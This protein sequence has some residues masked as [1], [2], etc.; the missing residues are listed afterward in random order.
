MSRLCRLAMSVLIFWMKRRYG[1]DCHDYCAGLDG[2]HFCI[3]RVKWVFA[4]YEGAI[5]GRSFG[6]IPDG[7]FPVALCLA[8][9]R[10][11]GCWRRSAAGESLCAAGV[12]DPRCGDR[13]HNCVSCVFESGDGAAG[14]AGND[15]VV[16]SFLCVPEE[17][18]RNIYVEGD[19][20]FAQ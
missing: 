3:F 9:Q 8:C 4:I 12:D 10:C 7:S 2:H 14:G 11:A 17:F 15:F 19:L 6:T 16:L 18:C 1:E 5:A 20:G 13:E